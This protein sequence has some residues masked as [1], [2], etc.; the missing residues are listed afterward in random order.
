MHAPQSIVPA[1]DFLRRLSAKFECPA[2][3]GSPGAGAFA[4]VCARCSALVFGKHVGSDVALRVC[5]GA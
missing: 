5:L 1:S 2:L 3:F 4:R